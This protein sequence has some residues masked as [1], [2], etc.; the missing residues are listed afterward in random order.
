[1]SKAILLEE[2][3]KLVM[4]LDGRPMVQ[5]IR[6]LS[7][8]HAA[9]RT[10]ELERARRMLAAGASPNAVLDALARGITNKLLHAPLSALNAAGD[11]ERGQLTTALARAYKLDVP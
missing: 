2:L 10:E 8:H 5:V 1:M 11:A 4:P 7:S 6:A 9:V 3:A